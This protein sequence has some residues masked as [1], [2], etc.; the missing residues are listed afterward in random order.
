MSGI[1]RAVD[2]IEKGKWSQ[3]EVAKKLGITQPRSSEFINSKV[4]KFSLEAL[5]GFLDK[6][7]ADVHIKVDKA[8]KAV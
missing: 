4:D 3:A 2:W 8:K 5:L 1:Y 7:G 6:I